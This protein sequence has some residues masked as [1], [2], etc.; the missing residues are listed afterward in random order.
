M[1]QA[2]K[3]TGND[4]RPMLAAWLML[5]RTGGASRRSQ[6]KQSNISSVNSDESPKMLLQTNKPLETLQIGEGRSTADK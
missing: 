1:Y 6:A 2:I 5:R 3:R 4:M